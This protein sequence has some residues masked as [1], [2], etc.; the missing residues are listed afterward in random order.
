M[1]RSYK[2]KGSRRDYPQSILDEAKEMIS[3]GESLRS[4]A[5]KLKIEKSFLFHLQKVGDTSIGLRTPGH[6]L[7]LTEETE[8]EHTY[9]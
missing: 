2:P 6:K 4:T 5:T 7:A 1:V 8:N 3:N 9:I